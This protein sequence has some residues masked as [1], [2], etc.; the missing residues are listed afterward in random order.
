MDRLD[1]SDSLV[2]ADEPVLSLSPGA[3]P[4]S[5]LFSLAR[6]APTFHTCGYDDDFLSVCS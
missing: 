4:V 5:L 1:S 2:L 6:A 3:S